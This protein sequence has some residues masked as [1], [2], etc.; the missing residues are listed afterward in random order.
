[1]Y[2]T[3]KKKDQWTTDSFVEH[4]KVEYLERN[5]TSKVND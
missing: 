4:R 1:M 5:W 2:A 3:Y